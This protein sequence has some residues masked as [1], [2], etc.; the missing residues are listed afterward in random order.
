MKF[1]KKIFIVFCIVIL[2]IILSQYS[3]LNTVKRFINYNENKYSYTRFDL[4]LYLENEVRT[5]ITTDVDKSQNRIE[6]LKQFKN[7]E[8]TEFVEFN[9]KNTADI[10]IIIQDEKLLNKKSYSYYYSNLA[11][12]LDDNIICLD[13]RNEI[14]NEN[15]TVKKIYYKMDD[16]TKKLAEKIIEDGNKI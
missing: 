5:S 15:S 16:K 12:Y 6:L 13:V 2:I 9:K 14:R 4:T 10:G 7:L 11:I 3:R 8:Q 1:N